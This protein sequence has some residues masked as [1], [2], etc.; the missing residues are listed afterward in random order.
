MTAAPAPAG[1]LRRLGAM[2]YDTL[3]VM[4]IWLLTLFPMVALTNN[5]VVGAAVQS[6]LFL[7]MAA[8]FVFFWYFRGQTLG[9]LAWHLELRSTTGHALS[10]M[11]LIIRFF[12]A[13]LSF[14]CLGLGYFW[15]FIDPEKRSWSDLLSQSRI[16]HIPPS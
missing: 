11:Q 12:A 13:I 14:A 5:A 2:V 15:I 8:F 4:A 9:M 10:P 3:L 1:F 7:E 6:L 16:L